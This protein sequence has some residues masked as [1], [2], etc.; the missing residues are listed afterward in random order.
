VSR[1]L[2]DYFLGSAEIEPVTCPGV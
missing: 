1:I 2:I